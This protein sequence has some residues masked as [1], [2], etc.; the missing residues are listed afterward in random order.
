MLISDS[1]RFLSKPDS[2]STLYENKFTDVENEAK[3][4]SQAKPKRKNLMVRLGFF[5]TIPGGYY[6]VTASRDV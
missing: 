3:L 2:V 1:L 5:A 6:L 4:R